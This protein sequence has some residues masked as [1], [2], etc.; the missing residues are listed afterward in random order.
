MAGSSKEKWQMD[1]SCNTSAIVQAEVSQE[2]SNNCF[3]TDVVAPWKPSTVHLFFALVLGFQDE[4]VEDGG[5]WQGW[6][7]SWRYCPIEFRQQS[8]WGAPRK[9]MERGLRQW[10]LSGVSSVAVGEARSRGKV[11][12]R[13]GKETTFSSIPKTTMIKEPLAIVTAKRKQERA[14]LHSCLSV[15]SC[16]L[17]L[18]MKSN[19]A[20]WPLPM[21]SPPP[22][23]WG[24][25]SCVS[26]MCGAAG[27]GH[28]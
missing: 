28:I 20:D 21:A 25:L 26:G 27:H 22:S 11:Q 17:N 19:A 7:L 16:P 2:V 5:E 6:A 13:R 12:T 24:Q 8:S 4:W 9:G 18:E 15:P 23:S 3:P 10:V 1:V 14:F